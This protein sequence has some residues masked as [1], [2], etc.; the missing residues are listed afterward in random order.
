MYGFISIDCQFEPTVYLTVVE[1]QSLK[2]FGDHDLDLLTLSVTWPLDSQ[3]EVLCRWFFE[4]IP[5][6][7]MVAEIYVKDLAI[8]SCWTHIDP[9]FCVPGAK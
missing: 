6:S 5:L 8:A 1:M 9:R 4:T 7:R 2:D 3:Y